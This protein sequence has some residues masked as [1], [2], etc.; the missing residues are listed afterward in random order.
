MKRIGSILCCIVILLSACGQKAPTWQEQYDLGVRYLEEGNYEEAIIAF[1]AAIEIDPK[2]AL[3]Y[4]GRGDAYIGSGETEENLMAAQAD[5]EAA[6]ALDG[7]IIEAWLGLA[8][9]YIRRGQYDQALDVLQDC[10]NE[11]G[12]NQNVAAKIAEIVEL[13]Q[14]Q[15]SDAVYQSING[16]YIHMVENDYDSTFYELCN[17]REFLDAETLKLQVALTGL[18]FDGNRFYSKFTGVGLYIA[19]QLNSLSFYYGEIEN[20]LPNGYG[21][22]IALGDWQGQYPS[23]QLFGG[24]W[25]NGLPNGS[26]TY[27]SKGGHYEGGRPGESGIDTKH[28][29]IISGSFCNGHFDGLMTEQTF[30]YDKLICL[31]T[32]R[33]DDGTVM[34]DDHWLY[35]EDLDDY[36]SVN[37]LYPDD[38]S[39]GRMNYSGSSRYTLGAFPFDMWNPGAWDEIR[40]SW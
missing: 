5:Y 29:E 14:P 13:E 3:A 6:V 32:I 15:I 33:Y 2:E 21:V 12:E 36:F 16:I 25:K 8:D 23:Y 18:I 26:G 37:E 4:V 35:R 39:S 11:I 31:S 17:Y 24:E 30:E 9:A 40:T 22:G 27:T 20:G 38:P 10:L 19:D 28:I 1:T 7:T 34:L